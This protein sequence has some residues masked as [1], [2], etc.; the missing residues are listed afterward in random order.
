[1]HILRGGARK[2]SLCGSVCERDGVLKSLVKCSLL[3]R[4]PTGWKSTT[5]ERLDSLQHAGCL[6]TVDLNLEIIR[7]VWQVASNCT[8]SDQGHHARRTKSQ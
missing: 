5:I 7:T 3:A 2:G 8:I 4:I 6:S 1:M